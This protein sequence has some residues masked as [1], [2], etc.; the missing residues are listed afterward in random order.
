MAQIYDPTTA[1]PGLSTLIR[2]I[3]LSILFLKNGLRV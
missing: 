2:N 3:R 1:S